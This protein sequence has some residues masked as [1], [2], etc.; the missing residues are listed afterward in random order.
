MASPKESV[1][2][3]TKL[4]FRPL[5]THTLLYYYIPFQ[6]A[7]SYTALSVNVMNPSL[8]LRVFPRKDIT[9][10]LLMNT[11]L[12][13]GLYLYDKSHLKV[14]SQKER[15]LYSAFGAVTFS[16]GSVLIWAILRSVI[17]QNVPLCTLCGL[18][19]SVALIKIGT[20]YIGH[21][22]SITKKT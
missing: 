19:T 3:I 21:I 8:V 4:G 16:L 10:I 22:E 13:S 2:V 17:P 12:G 14:L 20:N 5:N 6:G 15:V 1:S 7:L 18:G 11:L 9:N